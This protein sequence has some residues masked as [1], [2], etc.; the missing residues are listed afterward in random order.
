MYASRFNLD[1]TCTIKPHHTHITC[2][3]RLRCCPD[4]RLLLSQS[5]FLDIEP[6]YFL[7]CRK[8][9]DVSSF[10]QN[11]LFLTSCQLP[12]CSITSLHQMATPFPKAHK[13]FLN[14][15]IR[16]DVKCTQKLKIEQFFTHHSGSTVLDSVFLKVNIS[17]SSNTLT[18]FKQCFNL[19]NYT[20]FIFLH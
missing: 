5:T 15:K 8:N 13:L 1:V 11:C 7:S 16:E 4:N 12:S 3:C 18:N 6:D 20:K 9:F 19:S 10:L 2:T 17:E 14:I